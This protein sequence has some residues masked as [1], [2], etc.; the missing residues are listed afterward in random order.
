MLCTK[1]I[2]LKGS[3]D[4]EDKCCGETWE[5]NPTGNR[6]DEKPA[7][8]SLIDKRGWGTGLEPS[9]ELIIETKGSVGMH[10]LRHGKREMS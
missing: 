7:R 4:D 5:T 1:E 2:A 8:N 3:G 10:R 6:G 9:V